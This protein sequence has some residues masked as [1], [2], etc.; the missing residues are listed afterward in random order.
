MLSSFMNIFLY[1]EKIIHEIF[2]TCNPR[3]FTYNT[4]MSHLISCSAQV[5]LYKENENINGINILA[6]L[7]CITNVDFPELHFWR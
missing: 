7:C 1:I 6:L 2:G 4:K 3:K 5:N